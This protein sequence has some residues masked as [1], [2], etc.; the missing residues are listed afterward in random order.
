[1]VLALHNCTIKFIYQFAAV[2][3]LLFVF[4]GSALILLHPQN[5]CMKP[6]C[7]GMTKGTTKLKCMF[8]WKPAE[9]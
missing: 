5:I 1:M 2:C 7:I 9:G 6:T 8:P 4:G 3:V